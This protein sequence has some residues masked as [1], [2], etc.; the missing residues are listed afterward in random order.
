MHSRFMSYRPVARWLPALSLSL[1]SSLPFLQKLVHSLFLFLSATPFWKKLCVVVVAVYL[2]I[3]FL[4]FSLFLLLCILYFLLHGVEVL[5]FRGALVAASVSLSLCACGIQFSIPY[6][7]RT[8]WQDD[9]VNIAASA[10]VEWRQPCHMS[11]SQS[12]RW[13]RWCFSPERQASPG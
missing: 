10:V 7:F 8:R 9:R 6:L 2:Y 3:C 13:S 12:W 4:I 1:S 5:Y 11:L